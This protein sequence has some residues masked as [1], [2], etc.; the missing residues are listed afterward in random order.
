MLKLYLAPIIE[1]SYTNRRYTLLIT[2]KREKKV[3]KNLN[4]STFQIKILNDN[5]KLRINIC[6]IFS[7][8]SGK[9]NL[10]INF[11]SKRIH[12]LTDKSNARV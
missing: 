2:L 10:N 9:E 1:I 6:T 4:N 8:D 12:M 11:L 7:F 3:I 5:M